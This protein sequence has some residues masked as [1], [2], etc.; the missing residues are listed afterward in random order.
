[1]REMRT[2]LTIDDDL[3]ALAKAIAH[4]RTISIGAAVSE[5]ARRGYE[6]GTAQRRVNGFMVFEVPDNAPVIDPEAVSRADAEDDAIRY[7]GSL[8]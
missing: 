2:T 6:A 7:G 3:L 8:R 4:T 5:L 1:M